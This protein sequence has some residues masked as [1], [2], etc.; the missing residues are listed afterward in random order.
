MKSRP[1]DITAIDKY[2]KVDSFIRKEIKKSF[3]GLENISPIAR[4]DE[5]RYYSER[6]KQ[7][8]DQ[9]CDIFCVSRN[10]Y[11]HDKKNRIKKYEK[12]INLVKQIKRI[13]EST[14]INYVYG[15]RKIRQI[16]IKEH[17]HLLKNGTIS[18]NKLNRIMR[19]HNLLS[20][21]LCSKVNA[22][23]HKSSNHVYD[24]LIGSSKPSNVPFERIG[25]DLCVKQGANGRKV[26]LSVAQESNTAYVLSYKVS[27]HPN[28]ELVEQTLCEARNKIPSSKKTIIHSDRG[29][30]YSGNS[31]KEKCDELGFSPSM[32]RLATPTDN[33]QTENIF[34]C[35]VREWLSRIV[36][37]ND[38]QLITEI[39][40]YFKFYN[41]SRI[42]QRLGTTP[43]E[44]FDRALS[45]E[46]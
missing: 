14:E 19:D 29:S 46:R 41:N 9:L 27:Y 28:I 17:P 24:N 13:Q 40:K 45:L 3:A 30:T 5:I 37:E 11:Y 16:L 38:K 44:A 8:I 43:K 10:A 35:M 26:Y 31:Y 2:T 7:P 6:L 23:L 36:I 34:S 42:H 12:E 39:E 32:S 15:V 1:I 20:R 18:I 33:G 21:A 22:V 25:T 4:Y